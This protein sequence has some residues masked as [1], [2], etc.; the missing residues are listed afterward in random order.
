MATQTP[1]GYIGTYKRSAEL[2]N[3][4][5]WGRK[6]VLLGLLAY[7]DLTGDRKS[8]DAACREADY[9][10]GQ[11]GPGKADIV[12]VGWWTGLAPGSILEPIVLLYRRTGEKRYLD[13]ANYIVNR[14]GEPGG[15]DLVRK[16]IDGVPVFRM[17]PGPAPV[18]K[19]YGDNG[20]SKAYEMMS[21]YE[22]LAELYRATGKPEYL[23]A[24]R[25]VYNNIDTTEITDPRLGFGLGA[26]VQRTHAADGNHARMDGDV[27]HGHVDQVVGAA[28]AF[29]RPAAL[30]RPDRADRL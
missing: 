1:D 23:E 21:C 6:Y 9:T 29:D 15:P 30:C 22:G 18:I 11:I 16:A 3:W 13:F 4:D 26:L 12:K 10:M 27:R 8:L 14:W 19:D 28:L 7:Y 20:Q 5:V 25:R 17:F 2:S 24:V